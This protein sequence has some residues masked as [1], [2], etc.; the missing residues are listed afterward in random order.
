M[1]GLLAANLLKGAIIFDLIG[2]LAVFILSWNV[3]QFSAHPAFVQV[4][5]E[6]IQRQSK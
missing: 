3:V 1:L 5:A 6:E 2:L 4:T